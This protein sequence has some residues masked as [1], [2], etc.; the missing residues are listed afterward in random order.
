MGENEARTTRLEESLARLEANEEKRERR[1]MKLKK[2]VRKFR[3]KTSKGTAKIEKLTA[4]VKA[5][6]VK[7][8]Y[9]KE[10]NKT[11]DARRNKVFD[12]AF[13]NVDEQTKQ[14]MM[15]VLDEGE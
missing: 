11:M 2:K 5:L 14:C 10:Q 1:I 4:T 7:L 3:A 9:I 6:N 12:I 15:E 13:K 8:A